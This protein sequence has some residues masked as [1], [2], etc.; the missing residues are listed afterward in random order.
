LRQKE[1]SFVLITNIEQP[2]LDGV[3]EVLQKSQLIK[4]GVDSYKY[5]FYDDRQMLQVTTVL[6]LN[7]INYVESIKLATS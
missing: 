5:G 1:E 4:T 6:K 2:E 3:I 7:E